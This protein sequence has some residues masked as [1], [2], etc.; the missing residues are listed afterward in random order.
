V[1]SLETTARDGNC[2]FFP[3]NGSVSAGVSVLLVTVIVS[4]FVD[5]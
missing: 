2:Q 3:L 5:L 1:V 4:T